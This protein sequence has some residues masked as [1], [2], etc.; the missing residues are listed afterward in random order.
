MLTTWLSSGSA[1][2]ACVFDAMIGPLAPLLH[3]FLL[4][5]S[6]RIVRSIASCVRAFFRKVR[7]SV[8]S[9]PASAPGVS[10]VSGPSVS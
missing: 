2:R 1:H 6:Y 5:T 4:I 8:A 3:G 7:G 10:A 9:T